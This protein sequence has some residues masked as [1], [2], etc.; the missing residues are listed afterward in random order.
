MRRT[1]MSAAAC[2]AGALGLLLAAPPSTAAVPEQTVT[3]EPLEGAVANPERGFYHHTETHYREDGSGYAPLDGD[4]LAGYRDEGITQILRVFYLERY[5][6]RDAIDQ[7]YLDL[8]QADFDTARDEGVSVIVRFAY[9]QEASGPD[10]QPPFGDAP[11]E[12][13]LTHI[14]QLTPVLQ[15]NGDVIQ[16]VQNGLV[17]LW[18]EGYYTDHFA[19]PEDPA[20]VSEEDWANRVAVT[21]ALLDAVPDDRSVQV[22]TMFWKQQTFDT[23]SGA[24]GALTE[25]EAFTGSDIARVGHHNDCFLAAPDDWGTF[26]SDP[27]SLDQDYLAQET[28]YVPMGGETCNPDAAD[29]RAAWPTASEEMERYHY[30]Y[31]NI[32]YH[33][34]VLAGWGEAGMQETAERLG[35][36]FVLTEST[37]DETR[38]TL[39]VS[40]RNDGWASPYNEREASI[41]AI[42]A[43]GTTTELPTPTNGD[44]RRWMPGE[45]V[46]MTTSVASLPAGDYTFALDLGAMDAGTSDDPRF[47]IRTANTDTWDA[48]TGLNLLGNTLTVTPAEASGD[49]P[50]A[51]SADSPEELAATGAS[52]GALVAGGAAA[53]M[54]AI[55]L[56][57]A[58]VARRRG[59]R[60]GR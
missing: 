52:T 58:V 30:S 33:P 55:G 32:D 59:V 24:E 23:T 48:D 22:R 54:I 25:E 3:Y 42:T 20:V 5:A 35:Y 57:A 44:S 27:I 37:I 10:F 15:S 31:L 53:G 39:S 41:Q 7:E 26:L 29:D 1:I 13:V 49:E 16:V 4:T 38:R 36:R 2:A 47:A 17:G 18:G 21:R 11:V 50:S 45:T 51:V 14:A 19:D 12:R 46:T 34:D 28:H 56:T 43:D 60:A 8:L 9:S 40:V 6:A